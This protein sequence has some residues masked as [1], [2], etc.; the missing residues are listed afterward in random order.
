MNALNKRT[1]EDSKNIQTEI[2]SIPKAKT[3]EK[4]DKEFHSRCD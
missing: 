4:V 3:E 2:L 1:E